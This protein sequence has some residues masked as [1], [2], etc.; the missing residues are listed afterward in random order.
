MTYIG[1]LQLPPLAD[2]LGIVFDPRG[3]SV[4]GGDGGEEFGLAR[5][6]ALDHGVCG[7]HG[8]VGM[9]VLR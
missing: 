7:W 2:E 4:E 6:E 9:V 8:G 1:V 5:F 3:L